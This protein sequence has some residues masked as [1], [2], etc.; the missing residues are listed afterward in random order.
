MP[1]TE[2]EA[3][4]GTI[5]V[6]DR[7]SRVS[8]RLDASRHAV[9][10][11]EVHAPRFLGGHVLRDVEIGNAPGDR[12]RETRRVEAGDRADAALACERTGP[13]ALDGVAERRDHAETGDDDAS[14]AQGINLRLGWGRHD[15]TSPGRGAGA[16][17]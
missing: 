8:D 5:G 6:G 1:G 3:Y 10:H 15:A 2:Y 4:A 13:A 14:L 16:R 11:E 7:E 12:A 17:A 9:L